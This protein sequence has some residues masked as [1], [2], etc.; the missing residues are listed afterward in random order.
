MI[1]VLECIDEHTH[2][3]V[4]VCVPSSKF[5]K[6]YDVSKYERVNNDYLWMTWNEML[7]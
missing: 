6:V 1:G 5:V 7:F 3:C 2:V 4:C